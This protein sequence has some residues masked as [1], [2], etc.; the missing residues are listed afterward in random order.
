MTNIFDEEKYQVAADKCVAFIKRQLDVNNFRFQHLHLHPLRRHLPPLP[1]E[2]PR[3]G[4][5]CMALLHQIREGAEGLR[6]S[7][8]LRTRASD[9][10]GKGHQPGDQMSIFHDG[11][12]EGEHPSRS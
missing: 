9:G 4:I 3:Q 8:G 12:P 6:R 11:H 7:Y 10:N 1:L 2:Q 5:L